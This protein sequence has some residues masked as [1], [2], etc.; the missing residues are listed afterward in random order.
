MK[1]IF[2]IS[3]C[4]LGSILASAQKIVYTSKTPEIKVAIPEQNADGR[5]VVICPGGGYNHIAGAKESDEWI[6][7]FTSK[8]I[9][10]IT[11]KYTLPDGDKEKALG[12]VRKAFQLANEHS[13][14][15]GI[16]PN[17]IGIMGF[18]AG[19]HLASAYANS[20][21]SNLRPAF[22]ILFYPV[23]RLDNKEHLGMAKK[24]LGNEPTDK[25]RKAWSTNNMVTSMTPK[26]FIC[27]AAADATIDPTNSTM[28]YQALKRRHIQ[29]TLH[30]YPSGGHGFGARKSFEYHKQMESDLSDW[31]KTVAVPNANA[32]KIACIGNSITYGARLKYR[33]RESYPAQLQQ[34]LG[35]DYWIN[36]Y[37]VSGT[38]MTESGNSF[39]QQEN[40]I[41]AKRFNPDIVFIKLGTNDIQPRY[42]KGV[43]AYKA[44]YQ[45][46]I[47]ELEA[48]PSK[49]RIV[50]CFP[51]T[52]YRGGKFSDKTLV[53]EII[54]AIKAIA[55]KNKLDVIDLHTPTGGHEELFPDKLH[56]DAEGDKIIATQLYEY[57]KTKK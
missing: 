8:G 10:V 51:A 30:I 33:D 46:M 16:N 44:S 29:A 49:P 55:K 25:D 48:L 24:F 54:P 14:E 5:A 7:Y 22:E 11:T 15:W 37:G 39:M 36:N 38:T 42:W 53:D 31:L 26:T 21:W 9:A 27:V 35:H 23:I 57:L 40:Y 18:S 2:I 56:P 20:E 41:L 50:L 28:Y 43:D 12:D 47:D 34:M 32:K 3:I 6:P 1:K 52:C 13:K 19:G 17:G 45:K 4:L